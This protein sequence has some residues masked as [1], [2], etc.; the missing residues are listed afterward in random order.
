MGNIR[1]HVQKTD[2]PR[3]PYVRS[4]ELWWLKH[5]KY[6]VYMLRELTAAAVAVFAL[7]VLVGILALNGGLS[8]WSSWL[9]FLS[10]PVGLL[11][12]L[13]VMALLVFH[14]WSWFDIMPKTIPPIVVG[15]R[16]VPDAFVTRGGQI[17]F[18]L[19]TVMLVSVVCL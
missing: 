14:A 4:M 5:P 3:R 11:L 15:G 6:R 9:A 12:N 17:L 18:A 8:A 7:E 2:R 10:N 1:A 13:V 16:R 19:L